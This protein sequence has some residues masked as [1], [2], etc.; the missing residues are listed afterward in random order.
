MFTTNRIEWIAFVAENSCR[1]SSVH[2]GKKRVYDVQSGANEAPKKT[3]AIEARQTG[4]EVG[5]GIGCED[6]S[7]RGGDPAGV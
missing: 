4:G 1:V 7:G 6:G 5:D 3:N 2:R